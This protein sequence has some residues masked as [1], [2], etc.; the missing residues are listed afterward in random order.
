MTYINFKFKEIWA[1]TSINSYLCLIREVKK[2]FEILDFYRILQ[3]AQ[4]TGRCQQLVV[5]VLLLSKK[6]FSFR[7]SAFE[8]EVSALDAESREDAFGQI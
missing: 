8:K 5:V 4:R 7:V 2:G 1:E 6:P 3:R